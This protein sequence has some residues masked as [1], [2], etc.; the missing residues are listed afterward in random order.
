M[1]TVA[2]A[3]FLSASLVPTA[4][5]FL[6]GWPHGSKAARAAKR[7]RRLQGLRK[8]QE[9]RMRGKVINVLLVSSPTAN[10]DSSVDRHPQLV[11]DCS[12]IVVAHSNRPK[13]IW[14]R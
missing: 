10:F 7:K 1:L 2:R 12:F 8:A 4:A 9:R 11:Y 6:F 3:A 14:S 13:Q 5:P